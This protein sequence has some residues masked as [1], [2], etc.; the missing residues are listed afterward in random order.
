M[1]GTLTA[2]WPDVALAGIQKP[3][4]KDREE[5]RGEGRDVEIE[6]EIERER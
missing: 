3:V 5:E 2:L 1:R 6:R 4:R